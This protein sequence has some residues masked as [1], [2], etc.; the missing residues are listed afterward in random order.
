MTVPRGNV[1]VS[2][3]SRR[4]GPGKSR[5]SGSPFHSATGWN[6]QSVFVDQAQP[7]QRLRE[8]GTA[9]GD[10]VVARLALEPGNLLGQ[11]AAG[12]P[13]VRPSGLLQCPGEDD[14]RCVGVRA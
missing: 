12:D 3:S 13:G 11:V 7:G 2:A 1:L 8:G 9:V 5:N 14:L 10:D 6:H 4:S